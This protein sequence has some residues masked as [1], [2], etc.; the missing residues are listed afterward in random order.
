[1]H[2][3][4]W[5]ELAHEGCYNICFGFSKYIRKADCLKGEIE[6]MLGRVFQN[7]WQEQKLKEAGR[8]GRRLLEE[9]EVRLGKNLNNTKNNA[10]RL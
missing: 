1:M 4:L 3:A 9:I 5:K 2:R 8:S 6:V 10:W 7:E